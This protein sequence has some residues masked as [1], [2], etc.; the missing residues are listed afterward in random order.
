MSIRTYFKNIADAIKEKNPEILTV[1]PAEMPQAIL[2]IPSGSSNIITP[3]I[4]DMKRGYV[5][6]ATFNYDP[7]DN[8]LCDV[9]DI[10]K[11]HTYLLTFGTNYDNRF[12]AVATVENTETATSN[13]SGQSIVSND[14]PTGSTAIKFVAPLNGYLTVGKTNRNY[15]NIKTILVDV[16]EYV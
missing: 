3:N 16:T 9:Y 12:R 2:D 11:N 7:V 1:T 10:I 13:V 8:S 14:S 4:T 6:G 15:Q 5:Y